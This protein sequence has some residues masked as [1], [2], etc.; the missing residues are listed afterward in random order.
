VDLTG[1]TYNNYVLKLK[2]N[3]LNN[4]LE[5]IKTLRLILFNQGHSHSPVNL[6]LV[7]NSEKNI[8][9]SDLTDSTDIDMTVKISINNIIV[10]TISPFN[11]RF[12][13][14]SIIDTYNSTNI[15][16]R[17]GGN[18]ISSPSLDV[19]FTRMSFIAEDGTRKA[20]HRVTCY[21]CPR[22]NRFVFYQTDD[23]LS[24]VPANTPV[25]FSL[26][27]GTVSTIIPFR[28]GDYLQFN[29][30]RVRKIAKVIDGITMDSSEFWVN[31]IDDSGNI[32][33]DISDLQIINTT[34]IVW[35]EPERLV[36]QP[37]IIDKR[38][39][40]VGDWVVLAPNNSE[41]ARMRI[42]KD[43][44]NELNISV[45]YLSLHSFF[46]TSW[47]AAPDSEFYTNSTKR[48]KI[49]KISDR[50]IRYVDTV[51]PLD[52]VFN[53]YPNQNL[54]NFLVPWW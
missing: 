29:F 1:T 47:T 18:F 8:Q 27:P 36:L 54:P 33:E 34:N 5:E 2:W 15:S 43:P 49:S 3:I 50:L 4:P 42:T 25:G 16:F 22:G 30:G 21:N 19:L 31:F 24:V 20:S 13:R 44:V 14:Q 7:R 40:L 11:F 51:I 38:D 26:E 53:K 45:G 37:P 28:N 10:Y 23:R 12:Y 41:I 48:Y 6:P 52:S 9:I 17:N 39:D 46:I 32:R 35:A